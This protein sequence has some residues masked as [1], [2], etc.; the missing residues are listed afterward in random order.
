MGLHRHRSDRSRPRRAP[1][2]RRSCHGR[3]IPPHRPTHPAELSHRVPGAGSQGRYRP[4]APKGRRVRRTARADRPHRRPAGWR[5][6]HQ[7]GGDRHP[8]SAASVG[9][10]DAWKPTT[11][12]EVGGDD[13]RVA[14]A[15]AS[16]EIEQVAAAY[17]RRTGGPGASVAYLESRDQHALAVIDLR[18]DTDSLRFGGVLCLRR[19]ARCSVVR[20][21]VEWHQ[22]G[23]T[24][25]ED[26]VAQLSVDSCSPAPRRSRTPTGS[27]AGRSRVDCSL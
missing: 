6:R 14:G 21:P 23:Q 19:G 5:G 9:C 15:G 1:H 20:E 17:A 13:V 16:R 18:N 2:P 8:S 26:G 24:I 11:W 7:T 22:H 25:G 10:S 27:S 12:S 3:R 4:P